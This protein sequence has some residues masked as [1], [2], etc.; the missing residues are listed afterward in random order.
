MYCYHRKV[1]VKL[2]KDVLVMLEM[3]RSTVFIVREKLN[4]R[5]ACL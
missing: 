4:W 1:E 5:K 2:E 3:E